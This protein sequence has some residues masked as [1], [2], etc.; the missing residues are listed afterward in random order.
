MQTAIE[1]TELRKRYP[2]DVQ[3]LDGISLAVERDDLWRASGLTV[4]ASQ[5]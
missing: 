2:P 4:P 5:R 1:A 3:A